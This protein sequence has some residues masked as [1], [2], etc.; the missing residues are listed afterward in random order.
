MKIGSLKF[1]NWHQQRIFKKEN[2]V[3]RYDQDPMF[4]YN[5]AI[6]YDVSR[7]HILPR[8]RIPPQQVFQ[9]IW[10]SIQG[11]QMLLGLD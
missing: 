10:G 4:A 5:V 6:C 3:S 8:S 7:C 11:A 2:Q 9:S 1:P